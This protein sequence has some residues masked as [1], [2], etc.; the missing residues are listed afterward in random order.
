MYVYV[1]CIVVCTYGC[2]LM[3]FFF[4]KYM[5]SV[6]KYVAKEIESSQEGKGRAGKAN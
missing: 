1:V 6:D 4:L 3:R 2:F 5:S